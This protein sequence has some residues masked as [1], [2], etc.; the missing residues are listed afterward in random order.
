M[1]DKNTYRVLRPMD[2]DRLYAVGDTRVLTAQE[3]AHLVPLSLEL[4]GPASKPDVESNAAAKPKAAAKAAAP[5]AN[6]AAPIL[7]NKDVDQ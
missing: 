2:G 7:A 1:A 3:A 6:K 5:L 4:I